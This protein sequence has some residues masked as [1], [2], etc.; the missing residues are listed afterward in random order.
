M[1]DDKMILTEKQKEL[2]QKVGV[3]LE[4]F[5][6]TPAEARIS[7]LLLVATKT[8]LTFDEIK[9]SLG[10]SKSAVSNAI[11]KLLLTREIEY[12]TRH[13]DRKRYFRNNIHQW[14]SKMIESFARAVS[15]NNVFKEVLENRPKSTEEFNNHLNDLISFLDFLNKEIVNI[16]EE[17]L[18]SH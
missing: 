10:L 6:S 14:E 11:N 13:G 15:L 1:E 8:E 5:G 17:W 18:K 7:A 9:D 16:Y 3:S 12:V 4:Q 2:I